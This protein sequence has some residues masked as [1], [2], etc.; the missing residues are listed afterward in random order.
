VST[1]LTW[2]LLGLGLVVLVVRRRSVAVGTVTVQ[3]L[4]LAA[5]A[6]RDASEL[7]ERVAAAA[8]TARSLGLAT[9]FLLLI[10]R[11]R[12]LR[13]V[14]AGIAPLR[15]AGFAVALAL[16]LVALIPVDGLGTRDAQR[17]ILGLV[18]FGLVVAWSRRAT[19]FQ[20]LGIVLVENGLVL[21]ALQLP[22]TSWLIEI[23]VTI[24]LT[25][26]AV[27]AG[28]F[29][30]RIFTEFGAGDTEALRSLRE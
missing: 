27:V 2:V 25:L 13:L 17:S 5:L 12:E 16:L 23:G 19:L 20:I 8:L 29:H 24:D 4:V 11:T 21:A 28:V 1:G 3:S 18:A 7:N 15:R 14:R 9:F 22:Q 10:T 26:I 6:F 30:E